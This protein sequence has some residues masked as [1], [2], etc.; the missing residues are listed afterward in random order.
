MNRYKLSKAG[1]NA[2]EGI[3][4]FGGNMD[5]Y[6]Q[7]LKRFPA[8]T[9]YQAMLSAIDQQDV[10]AAFAAAHALKGIAGNLSLNRLYDD[11]CPL[12][13]VLRAGS[14]DNLDAY[15]PKVNQD[16]DDVIAALQEPV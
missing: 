8:D 12:V 1:V 7:F 10:T 3:N 9:N 2:T 15:L 5:K 4:R 6:E 14:L 13:E 11:I 16:Y